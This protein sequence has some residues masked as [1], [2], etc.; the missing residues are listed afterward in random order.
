MN[1]FRR[2]TT[3]TSLLIITVVTCTLTTLKFYQNLA[4]HQDNIF[5][6]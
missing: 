1:I 5:L 3:N 6:F 2:P 4:A